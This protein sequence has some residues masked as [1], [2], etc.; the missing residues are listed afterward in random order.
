MSELVGNRKI[1]GLMAY[2]DSLVEKGRAKSSVVTP[3]KTATRK[4]FETVE[5]ENWQNIDI[6]S[7]DLDDYIERFKNLAL[8]RYNSDSYVTYKARANRALTW[9]NNFLRNPGWTPTVRKSPSSNSEKTSK[10]G[11]STPSLSQ[12]N[13]NHNIS[14]PIETKP[15]EG[16][17][18][19]PFPMSNGTLASLYLP[20]NIT[21]ED[22]NRLSKFISSLVIKGNKD[23]ENEKN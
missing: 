14:A 18:S 16:L 2:L 9:Y 22:A 23:G 11:S 12:Q 4:I 8:D 13:I 10:R 19:L 1:S 5:K 7:I 21:E 3:L 20:I 6:A 15:K 17:I